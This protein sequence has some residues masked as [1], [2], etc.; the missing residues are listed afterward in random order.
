[1]IGSLP[2]RAR[3]TLPFALA[4]GLVLAALGAFL[5]LR[6]GSTLLASVDQGLG[7][8]SQEALTRFRDG[9]SLL[10]RDAAN[11]GIAEVIAANGSVIESSPA[12]LPRLLDGAPLARAAAA[13][14]RL[15]TGVPGLNGS[16]RLLAVPGGGGGW[17]SSAAPSTAAT[18]A[19]T[20][21]AMS[22]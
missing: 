7:G 5:Y 9:E 8:Q 20:I 12:G 15:T 21:C 18:R 22:S 4:M 14:A 13:G 16:W 2:I 6:V 19:S 10:D 1:M 17:S 3:L 11:S